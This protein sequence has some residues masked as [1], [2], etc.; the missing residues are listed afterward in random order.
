[1]NQ[2]KHGEPFSL[3]PQTHK[4]QIGDRHSVMINS[5]SKINGTHPK[6]IRKG[7]V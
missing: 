2:Q 1:M 5:N 6:L 4:Y 7:A 3:E